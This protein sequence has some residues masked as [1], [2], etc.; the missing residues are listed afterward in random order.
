MKTLEERLWRL[1]DVR[2]P[3]ECWQW[4]GNVGNEGYGRISTKVAGKCKL[5][6][7]HR[8]AW[9]FA[10]KELL[11]DRVARHT[12]DHPACCNPRHII[13]GSQRDNMLDA[14]ERGRLRPAQG[15]WS[16]FAKL[17]DAKVLS[18]RNDRASG[19]TLAQLSKKYEVS[20][21]V[22]ANV[23]RGNTWKHVGG[24]LQVD[25]RVSSK[26]LTRESRSSI[27]QEYLEG[28]SSTELCEKHQVSLGSVLDAVKEHGGDSRSPG[29]PPKLSPEGV[30]QVRK[31]Y[32]QSR[33]PMAELAKKFGVSIAVIHRA[34]RTTYAPKHGIV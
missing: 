7:T 24:P 33:T 14:M 31:E 32:G 23:Y 3:D 21:P 16:P 28:A 30:K 34:I 12:C 19:M 25:P 1:V 29:R 11:G 10:N 17:T 4:K 13:P 9:E 27:A 18:L 5:L 15:E 26:K 6:A 20:P 8:L 2:G 22:V